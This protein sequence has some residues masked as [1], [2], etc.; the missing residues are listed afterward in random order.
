M[1]A[2]ERTGSVAS[3]SPGRRR[4]FTRIRYVLATLVVVGVFAQVYLIASYFFG[5]SDALDIHKGVG[6]GVHVVE[7]LVFLAA[8]GASWGAWGE[9]GL[10]F[11]LALVG[12]IQ[13]ALADNEGGGSGWVHG[14][15]GLLALFVMV[16]AVVIIHRDARALRAAPSATS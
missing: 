16:I 13:L 7:V 6:G 11:S 4:I 1:A 3:V 8:F 10:S 14:L 12:T 15:H 5:A 2:S 9:F